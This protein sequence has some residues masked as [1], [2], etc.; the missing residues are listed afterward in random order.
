MWGEQNLLR[1]RDELMNKL[2]NITPSPTAEIDELRFCKGKKLKDLIK[3]IAELHDEVLVQIAAKTKT[4]S[5]HT[6]ERNKLQEQLN[7]IESGK[8]QI[9]REI[10]GYDE[11]SH[12]YARQV[13]ALQALIDNSKSLPAEIAL[14]DKS[15]RAESNAITALKIVRI[16][17]QIL[18]TATTTE[19][20]MKLDALIGDCEA[21][22]KS[23]ER[24]AADLECLANEVTQIDKVERSTSEAEALIAKHRRSKPIETAPV[25]E[26][27]QTAQR[28]TVSKVSNLLPLTEEE[29]Y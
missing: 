17:K 5:A 20:A 29:T 6:N 21:D 10:D 13:A 3:E 23:L 25:Y 14:Y 19:D 2:R 8:N 9:I 16:K 1:K 15:I 12:E 26:K 22:G 4:I 28:T 24:I 7:K 11:E 18:R 27:P